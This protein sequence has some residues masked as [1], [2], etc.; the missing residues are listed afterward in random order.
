MADR[1]KRFIVECGDADYWF[2]FNR[3]LKSAEVEQKFGERISG[4]Q[5]TI[6]PGLRLRDEAGHLWRP[7]L[8]IV[9]VPWKEDMNEG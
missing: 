9:L 6:F 8:R 4:L 1:Q 2:K 5:S 3:E 7:E